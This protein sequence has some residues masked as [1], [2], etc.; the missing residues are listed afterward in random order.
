MERAEWRERLDGSQKVLIG[1]GGEWKLRREAREWKLRQGDG[2]AVRTAQEER[3]S[4]A[5][6]ALYRLIKDKDYFIITMATDAFI[7]ESPLGSRT[8]TVISAGP[9]EDM[10]VSCPAGDEKAI[11][12]MD[13]IFPKPDRPKDSRWQRIVAPCGNETWRQCSV[14]CTKD[15]WE[16]GEVPDD[17][18]PHCGAALTGNTMEAASY[19]EEGYLPQWGRYTQWLAGTLNRE[20]VILELGV[21]FENPGVIRFPFEKTAFFNRRS[22]MY[23]VNETFPQITEELSGRAEGIGENSVGWILG[24]PN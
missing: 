8:E 1:L 4:R 15:I 18:C 23:R 10:A 19:I 17:I 3:L 20:L 16:P 13:R 11:A 7:Y 22:R 24:S 6:E 5:Y 2:G 14:P 12:L 9:E 21:G